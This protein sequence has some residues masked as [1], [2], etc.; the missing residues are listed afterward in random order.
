MYSPVNEQ[1]AVKGAPKFLQLA[2]HLLHS[3]TIWAVAEGTIIF[4]ISL[5]LII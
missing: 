5:N 4:S 1:Q 3:S 2:A